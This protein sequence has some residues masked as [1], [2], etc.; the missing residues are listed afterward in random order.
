MSI[1][2]DWDIDISR[3]RYIF[4]NRSIYIRMYRSRFICIDPDISI[5]T[6]WDV[7]ICIHRGINI[8]RDVSVC[9]H[10]DITIARHRPLSRASRIQFIPPVSLRS[11]QI[12]SSFYALFFRVVS[13]LRASPPKL[14]IH[15][16]TARNNRIFICENT[17]LYSYDYHNK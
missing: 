5:L 13:F 10:G 4:I 15:G 6:D 17:G 2:I 7:S 3:S 9:I 1:L 11:I 14:C 16:V 12:L 8:G